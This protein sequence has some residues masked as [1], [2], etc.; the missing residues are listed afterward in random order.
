MSF[1]VHKLSDGS[2][3]EMAKSW[4]RIPLYQVMQGI[5]HVRKVSVIQ[6]KIWGMEAK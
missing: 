4:Q 6:P 1:Y 3:W 2:I 5:N